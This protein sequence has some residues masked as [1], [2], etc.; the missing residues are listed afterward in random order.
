MAAGQADA[1]D[2]IPRLVG[3]AICD[4][5]TA[6]QSA[7]AIL[8]ALYARNQGYCGQHL[9]VSMFKSSINFTMC[10]LFWNHIW[11]RPKGEHTPATNVYMSELFKHHM[12]EQGLQSY[13]EALSEPGVA[14]QVNHPLFG[15]Y[16]MPK[17]PFTFSETRTPESFTP[18]F[19]P[20][21][22]T[23]QILREAGWSGAQIDE[24]LKAGD[25]HSTSSLLRDVM[26]DTKKA[27]V[28]QVLEWLQGSSSWASKSSRPASGAKGTKPASSRLVADTAQG[29]LRGV[30]VLAVGASSGCAAAYATS[31]LSTSGATVIKVER[32]AP[33]A[34]SNGDLRSLG[35]CPSAQRG[36]LGAMHMVLNQNKL[37]I[38]LDHVSDRTIEHLI[39]QVD[40]V[41]ADPE[42]QVA[43]PW[44]KVRQASPEVVYVAIDELPEVE[45]QARSGTVSSNLN[46][47]GEPSPIYQFFCSKVT[48]L[49]AATAAQ[50]ALVARDSK[51]AG[52]RG[53]LVSVSGLNSVLSWNLLDAGWASSWSKKAISRPGGTPVCPN[54]Q[55]IYSLL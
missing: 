21:E 30:V 51:P 20:G 28:F 34:G 33:A 41:V 54:F 31:L 17:R 48:G 37:S 10:D 55:V 26:H 8:A 16:V 4:K 7:G 1:A 23:V 27:L 35:A 15:A 47:Q 53:Q 5:A 11:T 9:V 32:S 38:T 50:A 18:A 46:L 52:R 2:G 43:L 44:A 14:V 39:Q 36:S 42:G 22:H 45:L 19:M 12:P 40:I 24:A 6:M 3:Q 49:Y 25:V 13:S 29:P